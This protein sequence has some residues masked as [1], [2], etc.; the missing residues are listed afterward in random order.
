MRSPPLSV[1]DRSA[2]DRVVGALSF[3]TGPPDRG[4]L[5]DLNSLYAAVHTQTH[6]PWRVIRRALE[7]RLG[8]LASESDALRTNSQA[9]AV[10]DLVWDDVLPA[11]REFHRDLLFHLPA[12]SLD[13][14]LFIGRV[15]EATLA[16]QAESAGSGEPSRRLAERVVDRLNDF[17]GYRPV[18]VLEGRKIEPYRHEWCRPIPLYIRDVA[19]GAGPLQPLIAQTLDILRRTDADLLRAAQFAPENLDELAV[20]PRA[21][22]FDHPVNKRPNHHFGQWDPHRLNARGMYCRFVVQQVTL[23]ALLSRLRSADEDRH[24][25]YLFEAS[26]VLAGTILMASGVSG[27]WPEAHDS[28]T[29]L[30]TLLPEVAAYRDRFYEQLMQQVGEPHASRLREEAAQMHQ[31]FAHARQSL[32]AELAHRRAAQR[33]RVHLAK[34]FARMGYAVPAQRQI[35][36]VQV[37]AARMTCQIECLLTEFNHALADNRLQ[38]CLELLQQARQ[39]ML[40]AIECGAI[41]DPWN[42]LG[43]DSNFSLFR[44]L[45]NSVPDDRIEELVGLVEGML[46]RFARLWSA[47]A[48][49]DDAAISARVAAAF[50]S[51][52][53]WW[54]QYAAH[55]VGSLRCTAP[56]EAFQAAEHVTQALNQWHKAGASAGDVGFW[57]PY[58]AEFHSSKAYGLVID[59]LLDR[60][61]VVA[62]RNL[63]VHWLSQAERVPL[64]DGEMSFSRAARQWLRQVFNPQADRIVP[65]DPATGSVRDW[66]RVAKFLDFLE[67]NAGEHWIVPT[68]IPPAAAASASSDESSEWDVDADTEEDEGQLDSTFDAAYEG[69]VYRD[70][71]DDGFEGSIFDNRDDASADE[72]EREANHISDR[73]EFLDCMSDICRLSAMYQFAAERHCSEGPAVCERR[74]TLAGWLEGLDRRRRDLLTLLENVQRWHLPRGGTDPE[75]VMQYDRRRLAKDSLL[76]RVVGSYVVASMAQLTVQALADRSGDPAMQ[77]ADQVAFVQF[78]RTALFRSEPEAMHEAWNEL[79]QALQK[80]PVLYVPVARGGS[81][82]A[83]AHVRLRHEM[84]RTL[85]GYLSRLGMV[86]EARQLIEVSR[87]MERNSPVGPAAVTEFDS[88]F[89]SGYRSIVEALVETIHRP[90][91]QSGER[92]PSELLV[93]VLERVTESLLLTWIAHSRTLRL[94]V[95][96]RVGTK[97]AWQRLVRFIRNYGTEIFTQTFLGLGNVRGILHQGVDHWLRQLEEENRTDLYPKLFADLDGVLLREQAVQQISLVLETIMEGYEEYRDYNSTTTQSD[98]GENLYMLLDFLRLKGGYERVVWNMRPVILAHEILVQRGLDEA[99]E[100]WRTALAD[101]ISDEAERY[102]VRLQK[103]QSD[104]GLRLAS[105]TDRLQQRFLHALV[106]DRICALVAPAMDVQ[107]AGPAQGAFD[108]LQ[109]YAAELLQHPS[110]SGWDLPA[111]L[112]K[113]DHEVQRTRWGNDEADERALL[114]AMFTPR[115]HS[116]SHLA[117]QLR[118]W[119]RNHRL[120]D[121]G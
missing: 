119:D 85:F 12:D 9:R 65:L 114:A 50:E 121:A 69:V 96:E 44:A 34:I 62:S 94:S 68:G 106:V 20:D 16:V 14:P 81:P 75:S 17:V 98:R 40:R 60:K 47:A 46:D 24:N 70:S 45:E 86:H 7:C 67:A 83:L 15:L 4:L 56:L 108:R 99:A 77:G 55:E 87:T 48:A 21:Y 1:E 35:A 66:P 5:R 8:Q 29:T 73:L 102:L 71:T 28:T 79:E 49:R 84:I 110:G 42:M 18:A 74:A 41:V 103:L 37:P 111:W 76:E 54:N 101:R 112:Q 82:L 64:E 93:K 90:G 91:R 22:D 72:F 89:E 78:L 80:L 6:E 117:R 61:D 38:E 104:Y 118:R 116:L 88:L 13:A 36:V 59:A 109:Q 33:E 10:L 2:L 115:L 120:E 3:A 39:T 32:N 53:E 23:D 26:A 113:L 95:L 52:A 27:G 31:P 63:L 92:D 105:V 19:I 97:E 107:H 58:V 100:Q 25:E 11:Y 51:F 57:A 43:F 30:G